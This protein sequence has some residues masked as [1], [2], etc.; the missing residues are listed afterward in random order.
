MREFKLHVAECSEI[1]HTALMGNESRHK[2]K[3]SLAHFWSV[4]ALTRGN[5]NLSVAIN[6]DCVPAAA[7]FR[8][9]PDAFE[10]TRVID[11]ESVVIVCRKT[12]KAL[13][14]RMAGEWWMQKLSVQRIYVSYR[15]FDLPCA[16]PPLQILSVW[17]FRQL[18]GESSSISSYRKSVWELL[19]I[20]ELSPRA[21]DFYRWLWCYYQSHFGKSIAPSITSIDC[22]N[23]SRL[24][25]Y[26]RR[27]LSMLPIRFGRVSCSFFF[28][29]RNLNFYFS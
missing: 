29:W 1:D 13:D 26:F 17:T 18:S 14:D 16:L 24:Y 8:R 7:H 19:F 12:T 22:I 25:E 3:T 2:T 28:N 27:E 23:R 5:R 20:S 10:S 9:I 4:I 6:A 15:Q 21:I 11:S